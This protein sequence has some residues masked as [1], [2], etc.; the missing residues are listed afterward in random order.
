VC[1]RVRVC[2]C[3]CVCHVV[4]STAGDVNTRGFDKNI[5]TKYKYNFSTV[6]ECYT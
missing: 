3:V 1:V 6:A 4:I 5:N 2:V